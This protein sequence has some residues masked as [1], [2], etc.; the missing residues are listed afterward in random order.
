MS[1][2]KRASGP[3]LEAKPD[4]RRRVL[5]LVGQLGFGGS[6]GQLR[7][8]LEHFD[9]THWDAHVL[10]FHSSPN[11]DHVDGLRELGIGVVE[12]PDS[13]RSR[14]RKLAFTWRLARRVRPQ[15]IHSWTVHDNPYAA[16]AGW[17]AGVPVR[18]GSVRG[19]TSLPGFRDLP[20][21]QKNFAL[22]SVSRLTVNSRELVEELRGLGVAEDRILLL[23]NCVAGANRNGAAKDVLPFDEYGF[24]GDSRVFGCVGNIRRAKNQMLFVRAMSRVVAQHPEARG[25]IVG[26][27]LAG[28]EATRVELEAEIERLGLSENVVL[29]GF[30]ADAQHLMEHL[31]ALCLTSDSEGMPNVVLEAMAAEVPVIA[32]EVGGVCEVVIDGETGLLVP[33]GDALTLGTAMC[34]VLEAQEET[35]RMART[36]RALVERE[37]GCT[38]MARRLEA[39]YAMALDAGAA[40]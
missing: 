32:T 37:R 23:P 29:T 10:V 11:A 12:M 24:S 19:S 34:R 13:H 36:A 14:F 17:L 35:A 28:E 16:W 33:V 21:L 6:E 31:S 7:L 38:L 39:E 20:P 27:T 8:L 2:S 30:R 1:E 4:I 5:F 40:S 22:H 15:V 3:A 18:W 9:R 25:V 26:E